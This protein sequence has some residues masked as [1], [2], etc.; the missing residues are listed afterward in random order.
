MDVSK[1]LN[2][3]IDID[4]END[5]VKPLFEELMQTFNSSAHTGAPNRSED[6][7]R[8]LHEL[9][10]DLNNSFIYDYIPSDDNILEEL[11]VKKFIG[12]YA[13]QQINH[14]V[15]NSSF[16]TPLL[17]KELGEFIAKKLSIQALS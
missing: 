9:N 11:G 7:A 2:I 14:I 6:I 10:D 4:T 16:N 17:I 13:W 12:K 15:N 3:L 1:L 8:I 5:Y